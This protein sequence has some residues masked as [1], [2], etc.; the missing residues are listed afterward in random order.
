MLHTF[1]F[2]RGTRFVTRHHPCMQI[3]CKDS[4]FINLYTVANKN[5]HGEYETGEVTSLSNCNWQCL[6]LQSALFFSSSQD[7]NVPIANITMQGEYESNIPWCTSVKVFKNIPSPF[8]IS[9]SLEKLL[10]KHRTTGQLNMDSL[11]YFRL[12]GW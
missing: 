1:R 7:L 3:L 6:E 9:C 12:K 5:K 10:L 2:C 8:C 11:L 4:L